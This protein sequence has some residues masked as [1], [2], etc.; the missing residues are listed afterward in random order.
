M[1]KK[2]FVSLAL[3]S[4]AFAGQIAIDV[5]YG[6]AS[7]SPKEHLTK[8]DSVKFLVG[9][10]GDYKD[11]LLW[12]MYGKGVFETYPLF[13]LSWIK[14]ITFETVPEYNESLTVSV[15]KNAVNEGDNVIPLKD[16][17]SI[18]F[19]DMDDEL[20][21]DNDGYTDVDELFVIGSD[22]NKFTHKSVAIKEVS[23]YNAKNE[24]VGTA[25]GMSSYSRDSLTVEVV[26]EEPVYA[27]EASFNG[28]PV[29]VTQGVDAQ[30]FTFKIPPLKVAEEEKDVSV[31]V[32]S[33]A[34]KK[35]NYTY[36]LPSGFIAYDALSL[37]TSDHQSI[38]VNFAP[39][40]KDSRI[41]GYVILRAEASS[42]TNNS[43]LENLSLSSDKALKDQLPNGVTIVKE[44][45]DVS[46]KDY[47]WESDGTTLATYI[48]N[49]SV[50][51]PYYTYRVV[52]YVKE[53]INGKDVYSYKMT[54][55]K[56]KRVG[57]ILFQYKAVEF[58]TEYYLS[59]CVA[60]MRLFADFDSNDPDKARYNY[61]IKSAGKTL[62]GDIIWETK[63]DNDNSDNDAVS[64]NTKTYSKEVSKDG[65][66][67]YLANNS[68]CW[69]ADKG[70]PRQKISWS[71]ANMVK[72]LNGELALTGKDG[73]APKNGWVESVYTYGKGGVSYDDHCGSGC[74]DEP[75][76]GWKFKFYYD[77]ND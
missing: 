41:T 73:N 10:S 75:R 76:A 21:S 38:E 45:N 24:K 47:T 77:W 36:K 50:P 16:V 49:V 4:S 1:F 15:I 66:T 65:V 26:T 40:M 54:V 64:I 69:G 67:L 37:S 22:P 18:D 34:K 43:A 23:F 35:I 44:L 60:D 57:H 20:D 46:L 2:L 39:S 52:A 28:T 58:G 48:D 63:A 17:K 71:Y 7:I 8:L 59:G 53:N 61:F 13:V 56:T 70:R 68:D 62:S 12:A 30:H 6:S 74:G 5:D 31:L 27:I 3:A 19:F 14:N 72:A 29:V 25:A 11:S 51:S 33:E 55:A 32:V 9:A 42:S